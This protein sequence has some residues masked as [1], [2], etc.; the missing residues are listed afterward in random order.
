MQSKTLPVY[1][2][3]NAASWRG[4]NGK[5]AVSTV[6]AVLVAGQESGWHLVMY[7]T[8]NGG[9]RVGYVE[10]G[11]PKSSNDRSMWNQNLNFEYKTAT[12][13]HDCALT[14]DPIRQSSAIRNLK[15]GDRVT[16]LTTYFSGVAWDY[17]ETTADNGQV[18]RGFIRAE[19]LE[20]GLE[21]G[22][23]DEAVGEEVG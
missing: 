11:K 7:E 9:V 14:D 23:Q 13:T 22:D 5:A 15:A 10:G 6:G 20:Q 19:Y 2:A 17:V 3:P 8:N 16:Y 12:V 18:T 4:A 21:D 1:S